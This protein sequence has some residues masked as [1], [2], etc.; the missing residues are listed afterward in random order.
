M[1]IGGWQFTPGFWPSL[2]T[3][4]FLSLFVAL[5]FWQLDRADQK[6]RRHGEFIKRQAERTMDLTDP[7]SLRTDKAEMLWRH[8]Q[9]RGRFAAKVHILLDNQV[10]KGEPGYLVFTP[11]RLS[12]SDSWLLINRGWVPL[13]ADRS[14]VPALETPAEEVNIEGVI[15]DV[16]A[17]GLAL[18]E[19]SMETLSSS[20]FRAQRIDLKEDA[21]LAGHDLQP[22]VLTLAPESGYGFVREWQIPG[23]GREKHLGYAFQWFV[24][25]AALLV[26]YL[27][28]N[29]TKISNVDD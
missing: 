26:I 11:F 7:G 27:V 19:T 16:P 23:S 12:G 6:T 25:A 10:V 1:R 17:T 15:N 21:R 13:G 9:A 28:V 3:L 4:I 18:G 8:V 5:G 22:Y 2:A 14:V 29:V 20:I 24:F